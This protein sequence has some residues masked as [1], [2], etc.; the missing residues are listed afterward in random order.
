MS[1][2]SDCWS[3]KNSS[4]PKLIH[5]L[6]VSLCFVDL[7]SVP[8]NENRSAAQP[9]MSA[10]VASAANQ[11]HSPANAV[12]GS[13]GHPPPAG[14]PHPAGYTRPPVV[15]AGGTVAPTRHPH[16]PPTSQHPLSRPPLSSHPSLPP[17]SYHSTQ[18]TPMGLPSSRPPVVLPMAPMAGPLGVGVHPGLPI[19]MSVG[20]GGPRMLPPPSH[21]LSG[22]RPPVLPAQTGPPRPMRHLPPPSR[23]PPPQYRGPPPPGESAPALPSRSCSN[24]ASANCCRNREL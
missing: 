22:S 12:P 4:V 3:N 7:A 20:V 8:L 13:A 6:H 2:H 17:T 9:E 24:L 5:V 18:V 16:V 23:P 1:L 15:S 10:P 19:V 14:G 21:P 11:V